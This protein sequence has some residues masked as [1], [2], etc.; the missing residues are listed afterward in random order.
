LR[1][2]RELTFFVNR[3]WSLVYSP[4]NRETP[5]V[6]SSGN[7][8]SR[9]PPKSERREEFLVVRIPLNIIGFEQVKIID[10]TVPDQERYALASLVMFIPSLPEIC[11]VGFC[12]ATWLWHLG[13]LRACDRKKH[14]SSGAYRRR[15]DLHGLIPSLWINRCFRKGALDV[16]Q[17]PVPHLSPLCGKLELHS[18]VSVKLT[19]NEVCASYGLL[20]NFTDGEVQ[21]NAVGGGTMIKNHQRALPFERQ[22]GAAFVAHLLMLEEEEASTKQENAFSY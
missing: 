4:L 13:K 18:N 6:V 8:Y 7:S 3:K 17:I 22:G 9:E 1:K 12:D 11:F 10:Q 21:H 2:T 15:R 14:S 19:S 16:A 20:L 5:S